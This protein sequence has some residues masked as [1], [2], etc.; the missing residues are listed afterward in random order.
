MTARSSAPAT[1]DAPPLVIAGHGTRDRA[2]Q[3]AARALVERVRALLPGVRVEAGFVELTPPSIDEALGGVLAAGARSAV[4]VPLM[5]GTGGHVR[6]D[7]PEAIAAGRR[8]HHGATVV[9]TR[10]LGAPSVLVGAVRQRIDDAR[11]EWPP[12][13][14]AVVLVGRGCSVTDANADHVRLARVLQESGG[15]RRVVAGFI[16]VAHPSVAEALDEAAAVGDR[17]LVVMPHY[18]FPG[19]LATWVR[20]QTEAWRREHPEVE[21]RVADVIGPCAELAEVVAQRY[22]EGALKARTDLGSPS[23]LSGL[24]L[25]GRKAVAVGGGCVNRRRIP[26]LLAAGAEV[27][28]VAPALH[29]A[30]A[31][32]VDAGKLG[33]LQRPF[34]DSDLDGAWY[35]LAATDDPQINAQVAAAAEA[36][37]TFCVRADDAAHGSAWT[38]AT[39]DFSG[40]TVAVLTDHNPQRSRMLRDHL[41]AVLEEIDEPSL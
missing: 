10:H 7:I 40:G 2:G 32:L 11:G 8:D 19:R 1:S 27:T 35:V 15:Y 38:P 24:L 36:R 39:G 4:V 31:T 18:L 23:Y 29:P 28:V 3:D 33:W 14:T 41:L 13:Q 21:V 16:Q 22:R 6:E 34:V 26:K 30:L 17:R 12:D 5:I 37:H 9:Y 25:S 20:Q